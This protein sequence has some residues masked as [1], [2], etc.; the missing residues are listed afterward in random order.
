MR[1]KFVVFL[2]ATSARHGL[3]L[4]QAWRGGV[5]GGPLECVSIDCL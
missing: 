2:I 3:A 5:D 1:V 4:E